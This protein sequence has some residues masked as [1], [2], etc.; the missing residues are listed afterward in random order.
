M[1]APSA[2]PE[3]RELYRLRFPPPERPHLIVGRQRYEVLDCS[4]RGLRLIITQHPLPSLGDLVEGQLLFRRSSHVPIRGLVIRIQN[5]EIALH[6]PESEI[7]FTILRSEERYL[8]NHYR[9]WAK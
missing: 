9:M 4:A 7:P 2:K 1:T 5:G 8:L 6:M 3:K